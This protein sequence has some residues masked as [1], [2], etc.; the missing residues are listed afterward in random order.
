MRT[1]STEQI[2][3]PRWRARLVFCVMLVGFGVLGMRVLH[4]Q[5]VENER[6]RAQGD[7]RYLRE[8]TVVPQR[9]RIV[10]RHGQVLAVS[11]PVDSLWA[12]PAL[13]CAEGVQAEEGWTRLL[14]ITGLSRERLARRCARLAGANFMYIKRRLSPQVAE[15]AMALGLPGLEVQTEYRRYYPGGPA[16][17]HLLGFT[18]VDDVGQEGLERAHQ[19]ELGGTRGRVRVLKDRAGNYVESVHSIQRVQHGEDLAVSIDQRIVALANDYLAAAVRE[20]QAVSGSVVVLAVPSGEILAMVNFPQF[21]PNDRSTMTGEAFR[22]RSITDVFEPG[23]TAKP[24]TVAMA[25]Q[26][27]KVQPEQLVDTAPGYYEIGGHKIHDTQNYGV[28]SVADV[29]IRSSNVGVA[30]IAQVFPYDALYTTFQKV[31]FGRRAGEFPGETAGKLPK[32]T[33]PVDHVAQSYGHGFAVTTL[34]LAR[35]YTTFATDGELL[36][37]TLVP[38]AEGYRARG[39]RI[40]DAHTVYTMREMLEHA[41]SAAGTA[42]KARIPR[43]R[44]GGKTGTSHKLLDGSYQNSRYLSNFVGFAPL[45][46]PRFV[47][48]VTIDDPRG[49]FYY[50]GDVA[51]P[52][53][54]D[55]M[56]DLL[57]LYNVEPDGL[58]RRVVAGYDAGGG[59]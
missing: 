4:L 36:P 24:F 43:Y 38:Q 25:L 26:S 15:E 51:A 31:G 55:L 47:V 56:Q 5:T 58:A 16:G 13:F 2:A 50:G 34:Q 33:S 32:R 46:A 20:H 52:V 17:A 8:V 57:R 22:N 59:E 39:E 1:K 28:I 44:V 23:S 40:F 42:S 37:V 14:E 30:K 45:S 35:A 29:I 6:L 10:D 21:N 27:G 7:A 48:A 54:A 19:A 12:Q 3:P 11:T 9:G 49:R 18:N 53:F 41:A